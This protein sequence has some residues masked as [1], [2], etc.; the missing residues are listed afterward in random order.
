MSEN[1]YVWF[2]DFQIGTLGIAEDG[3]GITDIFLKGRADVKSCTERETPLI[4][5]AGNQLFEYFAGKRKIFHL[6]LSLHGTEFQLDV[7]KALQTVPYGET[8]SYK[9]IA[10]QIGNPKACRA[11]GMANN[12]NPVMIVVPC[13]RIIGHDGGMVGYACGLDVK[14]YL[15]DLEKR[16]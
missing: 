10:E 12:R 3:V 2:Y 1:K 13:H 5:D 4:V 11:V 9:Q 6:P 16:N 7:W 15:L 14:K 8:R